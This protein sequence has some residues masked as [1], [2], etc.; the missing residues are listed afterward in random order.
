[1]RSLESP[2]Q[3]QEFI[4]WLAFEM[5]RERTGAQLERRVEAERLQERDEEPPFAQATRPEWEPVD[6]QAALP[7]AP[8]IAA[9]H[10][11]LWLV[12][13]LLK[14]ALALHKRAVE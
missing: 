7:P 13:A 4:W 11:A 10:L 12:A 3:S 6:K 8:D 14:S 2:E 5:K 1:L 9:A